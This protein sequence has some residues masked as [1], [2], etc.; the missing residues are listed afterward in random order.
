MNLVVIGEGGHS[1]VIRD[2][3]HS[4]SDRKIVAILD[5]KYEELLL[6]N[7]IYVGPTSSAHYLLTKLMDM[8]LIIAI[9]NN[10]LRKSIVMKLGLPNES[11]ITLIH[12]TAVVSSSATIGAGTV[13]MANTI[14]S[15]D[16]IIG[17]HA[18]VNSGAIVEHDNHVGDYVHI[19]PRATLTGAVTVNEGAMVGA[20]AN[21][22]PGKSI[23]EWAVVG[24][25]ATVINDILPHTTVVGTPAKMI[26]IRKF[27]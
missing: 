18:I 1:K 22:I 27:A 19:A 24:A 12:D 11:Y 7:G 10:E 4:K 6:R 2:L 13:I 23:G 8:K 25:G 20:G 3:I 9:G 14:V 17:D 21:V 5:D 15:A 16:A 26:T